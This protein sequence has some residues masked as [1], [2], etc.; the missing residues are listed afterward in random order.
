MTRVI[1]ESYKPYDT[2]GLVERE[3]GAAPMSNSEGQVREFQRWKISTLM[4]DQVTHSRLRN[5]MLSI[6]SFRILLDILANEYLSNKFKSTEDI[7]SSLKIIFDHNF[8][9]DLIN[10]LS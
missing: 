3:L 1:L 7:K 2:D 10:S 9:N 8:M 6:H 5:H 4:R